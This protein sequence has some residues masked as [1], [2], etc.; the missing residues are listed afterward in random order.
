M[1]C[2]RGGKTRKRKDIIR[3]DVNSVCRRG[4]LCRS[5]LSECEAK[6]DCGPGLHVDSCWAAAVEEVSMLILKPRSF[7][8]DQESDT[9]T[10]Q[11]GDQDHLSRPNV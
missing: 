2:R 7:F 4:P 5:F 8:Q 10:M 1:R 11:S 9:E 3:T 6:V